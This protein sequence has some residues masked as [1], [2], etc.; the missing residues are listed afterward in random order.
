MVNLLLCLIWCESMVRVIKLQVD[1]TATKQPLVKS[2]LKMII[3]DYRRIE[4][5]NWVWSQLWMIKPSEWYETGNATGNERLSAND[6][7]FVL[8]FSVLGQGEGFLK[9]EQC[10]CCVDSLLIYVPTPP[11]PRA[12]S[13]SAS[14]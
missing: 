9:Q 6:G 14:C 11:R 4:I 2:H 7:R 12:L 8:D 3:N 1:L 5:M 13:S 10:E